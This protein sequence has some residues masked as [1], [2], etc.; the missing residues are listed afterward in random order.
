[1]FGFCGVFCINTTIRD[2]CQCRLP[3]GME[4]SL[5]IATVYHLQCDFTVRPALGPR[6]V[7]L[8]RRIHAHSSLVS[9]D[10]TISFVTTVIRSAT[11][12]Q[13]DPRICPDSNRKNQLRK[14]PAASNLKH[15]KPGLWWIKKKDQIVLIQA[16]WLLCLLLVSVLWCHWCIESSY[17]AVLHRHSCSSETWRLTST[18]L[19]N[20][21]TLLTAISSGAN[22][23]C[24]YTPSGAR[25]VYLCESVFLCRV[26][27]EVQWNYFSDLF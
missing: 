1:M 15:M 7:C 11:S 24:C 21:H 12:K 17:V 27:S 25:R 10:D 5:K 6:Q 2:L 22:A 3:Q 18:T 20:F 16:W 4:V 19:L 9:P 23:R 26:I 14:C 13:D 8:E